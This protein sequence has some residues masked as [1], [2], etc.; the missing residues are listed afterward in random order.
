MGTPILVSL[1][2]IGA[3]FLNIDEKFKPKIVCDIC[4]YQET[5]AM[6]IFLG[7]PIVMLTLISIL[8]Y[9]LSAVNLRRALGNSEKAKTVRSQL[10][11]HVILLSVMLVTWIF[12]LLS[13]LAKEII[14]EFIVVILMSL[15]GLFLF[16]S[17]VKNKAVFAKIRKC[18]RR[19]KSCETLSNIG[20]S[21]QTLR[22]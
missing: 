15:Q 8:F 14:L 2:T 9:V 20:L 13:M 4:L 22:Y 3:N 7:I 1:I 18:I 17:F 5:Y 10:S 16:I 19:R 12:K 6:V 21:T 11:I